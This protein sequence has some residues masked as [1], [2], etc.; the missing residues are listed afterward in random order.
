MAACRRALPTLARC[1]R[2]RTAVQRFSGAH[3][4]R[5]AQGPDEN[6]GRAGRM[7]G[8][9]GVVIAMSPILTDGLRPVGRAWPARQ[10]PGFGGEDKAKILGASVS[11]AYSGCAAGPATRRRQAT[12]VPV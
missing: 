11:R 8:F 4:G 9:A 2:P 3:P 10:K 1:D 5:L 6:S 12:A 7:A